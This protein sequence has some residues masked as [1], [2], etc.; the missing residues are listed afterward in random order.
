[1][2]FADAGGARSLTCVSFVACTTE[3][4]EIIFSVP[5]PSPYLRITVLEAHSEVELAAEASFAT[6]TSEQ[7]AHSSKR[8]LE[9][10][11]SAQKALEAIDLPVQ[12][13]KSPSKS[14][15]Y[16]TFARTSPDFL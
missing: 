13:S 2:C 11:S 6:A 8:L 12:C 1:M 3:R 4:L 5:L 15:L 16:I 14:K 9:S 10:A 7:S